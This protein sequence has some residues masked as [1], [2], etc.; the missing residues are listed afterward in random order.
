M[1]GLDELAEGEAVIALINEDSLGVSGLEGESAFESVFE[2][3]EK[4][5]QL[6]T[7]QVDGRFLLVL[8]EPLP[9]EGFAIVREC[10]AEAGIEAG[11][12]G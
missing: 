1:A 8:V 12:G 5:G 4:F 3:E 7:A 10:V 9:V 6:V 2:S 11:A